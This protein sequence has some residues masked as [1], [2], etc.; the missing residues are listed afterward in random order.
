[1]S[2]F[3]S[4]VA[5]CTLQK[6]YLKTNKQNTTLI[7]KITDQWCNKVCKLTAPDEEQHLQSGAG[8]AL[9]CDSH[10]VLVLF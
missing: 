8:S 4:S 3:L 5:C 1:M 6:E 9:E 2:P 7:R 10:L